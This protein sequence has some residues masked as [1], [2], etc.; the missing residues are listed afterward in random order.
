MLVLVSSVK[1][2]MSNYWCMLHRYERVVIQ[3][4]RLHRVCV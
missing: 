3:A 4:S 1:Q 2:Y